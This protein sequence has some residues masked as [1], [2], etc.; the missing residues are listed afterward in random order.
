MTGFK[1]ILHCKEHAANIM[2]I[3]RKKDS[4]AEMCRFYVSNKVYTT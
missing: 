2:H 4:D 1:Q 3:K